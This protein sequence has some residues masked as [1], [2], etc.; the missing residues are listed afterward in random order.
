MGHRSRR[1]IGSRDAVLKAAGDPPGCGRDRERESQQGQRD[2]QQGQNVPEGDHHDDAGEN[3]ERGGLRVVGA[4]VS[5][6]RRMRHGCLAPIGGHRL[7]R[8]R[9]FKAMNGLPNLGCS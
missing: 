6:V 8:D 4:M 7:M 5:A 2:S 9:L 3:P 1:R